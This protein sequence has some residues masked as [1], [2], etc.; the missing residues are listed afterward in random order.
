[1]ILLQY[2]WEETQ[3]LETKPDNNNFQ[4][5]SSKNEIPEDELRKMLKIEE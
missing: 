4:I 2:V 1:M 5:P 3:K